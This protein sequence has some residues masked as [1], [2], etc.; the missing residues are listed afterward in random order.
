[1][2]ALT[3]SRDHARPASPLPLWTAMKEGLL[4][5][6][7]RVSPRSESKEART[8]VARW[9]GFES[10]KGR[11]LP[12]LRRGR[13]R[14]RMG[15]TAGRRLRGLAARA[16]MW[17][18]AVRGVIESMNGA[19]PKGS[20]GINTYTIASEIGDISRFASPAK[21]C[22]YTGLCPRVKQS[23]AVDARRSSRWARSRGAAGAS[24]P[25]RPSPRPPGA[26]GCR[27]RR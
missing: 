10:P 9:V 21:L 4:G 2:V 6:T 13:D 8:H 18:P 16:A 3:S 20:A 19:P 12:A 15:L 25:N 11:R 14:R 23:G 27:R 26:C 17:G 1:M 5:G 24:R 7:L 22:G